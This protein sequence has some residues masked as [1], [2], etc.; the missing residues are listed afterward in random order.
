MQA[1]L[2]RTVGRVLKEEPPDGTSPLKA[3]FWRAFPTVPTHEPKHELGEIHPLSNG[4]VES[5]V[6]SHETNESAPV[7]AP[8]TQGPVAPAPTTTAPTT[9]DL[10][11][12]SAQLNGHLNGVL[13]PATTRIP[14][15]N[16]T[17][18]EVA[19]ASTSQTVEPPEP[20]EPPSRTADTAEPPPV[21]AT[22]TLTLASEAVRH[23]SVQCLIKSGDVRMCKSYATRRLYIGTSKI[24]IPSDII[25]SW[26]SDKREQLKIDLADV[27]SDIRRKAA[28][29][30][31]KES[32][33]N[34]V[35]EIRMSGYA[36]RGSLTV[37]LEPCLWI[38]CGSKWA[39]NMI[40][41]KVKDYTWIQSFV[42][43]PVQVH[44]RGAVWG[45]SSES[46]LDITGLNFSYGIEIA[47]DVILY[48]NVE[49]YSEK[50][51]LC[52][53]LC[54]ATI[55][56]GTKTVHRFCRIGGVISIGT[57][58]GVREQFG[59]STAHSMLNN[60]DFLRMIA[61]AGVTELSSDAWSRRV[62]NE[63]DVNGSVSEDDD[64]EDE[65]ESEYGSNESEGLDIWNDLPQEQRLGYRDPT[66]VMQ[67]NNTDY[68]RL[69]YLGRT[70]S[71]QPFWTQRAIEHQQSSGSTDH[72]LLRFDKMLQ[73]LSV[74]LGNTYYQK[75]GVVL[76]E[77]T[78]VKGHARD[79][80]LEEGPVVIVC[81]P[82]ST[83]EGYLLAGS[84]DF[85]AGGETFTLRKIETTAVLGNVERA[86]SLSTCA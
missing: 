36:A 45:T 63:Q 67:W 31:S 47:D 84:T 34:V 16:G 38:L 59:L 60:P 22:G 23:P 5:N 20:P 50:S 4:H 7:P 30:K 25:Q 65:E 55:Q 73:Q 24:E 19:E 33:S 21:P 66:A 39:A 14:T 64:D 54:C 28:D 53:L 74:P 52:G 76:D 32:E 70:I 42:P 40:K 61:L 57:N 3:F 85:V 62:E 51:S 49:D 72:A 69:S 77:A 43:G 58:D 37:T 13:T 68:Q 46:E 12:G 81:T 17:V 9:Q 15:A 10:R 6:Q 18:P 86:T 78:S 41:E 80:E 35:C 29:R 27:I 71:S 75:D 48:I 11:T 8:T 2:Q 83:V 82:D 1:L 79:D 56:H 26:E 44:G